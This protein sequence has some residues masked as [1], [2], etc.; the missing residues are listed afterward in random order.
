VTGFRIIG[1]IEA[2]LVGTAVFLCVHFERPDLIWPAVGVAVSLHFAPLGRLFHV[3]AYYVTAA[4][5]TLVSVIVLATPLGEFRLLWLGG[6][7]SI[8]M[9]TSAVYLVYGADVIAAR[10]S[11]SG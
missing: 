2:G 7:M 1:L 8:V 10:T 11:H 3:P 9:W 5:G 6:G 4:A